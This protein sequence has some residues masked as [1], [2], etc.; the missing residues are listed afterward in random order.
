MASG[1]VP[2]VLIS[3]AALQATDLLE[4]SNCLVRWQYRLRLPGEN[5]SDARGDGA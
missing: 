4:L 3:E 5:S 1:S 2:R